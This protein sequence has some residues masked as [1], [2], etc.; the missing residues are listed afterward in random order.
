MNHNE[1]INYWS[2]PEHFEYGG[3]I[4]ILPSE[5]GFPRCQCCGEE[6]KTWAKLERA[7]IIPL[8]LGGENIP[9]NYF[10]LCKECHKNMPDINNREY[11]IKYVENYFSNFIKEYHKQFTEWIDETNITQEEINQISMNIDGKGKAE[12]V[13]YL[14]KYSSTHLG[15][16]VAS[17]TTRKI[18]KFLGLLDKYYKDKIKQEKLLKRQST[19]IFD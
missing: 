4:Y 6:K 9:S 3:W 16:T 18:P 5:K 12:F 14:M 8:S 11:I 13:E 15:D 2:S 1:I 17:V 10:L 7:H 19:F